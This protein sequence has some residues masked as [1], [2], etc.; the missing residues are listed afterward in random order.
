[1]RKT[2]NNRMVKDMRACLSKE[3]RGGSWKATGNWSE[4]VNINNINKIIKSTI[5]DV[6]LKSSLATGNWGCGAFGNDHTLKFLQQWLAAWVPQ[7][8]ALK[9]RH[10]GVIRWA[11][12]VDPLAI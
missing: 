5:L 4:I 12:D 9:A 1:M 11:V 6:A 8:H 7:L 10:K 3:I 2:Y